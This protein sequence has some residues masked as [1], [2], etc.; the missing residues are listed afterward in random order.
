MGMLF[1]VYTGNNEVLIFRTDD[2]GEG[3]KEEEYFGKDEKLRDYD[4]YDVVLVELPIIV[5]SKG[6][7]TEADRELT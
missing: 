6:L 1:K 5:R 4:E 3:I 7:E 2:G